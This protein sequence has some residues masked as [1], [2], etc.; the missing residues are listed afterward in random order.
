MSQTSLPNNWKGAQLKD[1]CAS[2]PQNG[3]FIKN[4]EFGSGLPFV[5]VKDIYRDIV[6]DLKSVERLQCDEVSA[7][8]YALK[9]DDILFVRSSLKRDGIGQCCVVTDIQEPAIYDCHLIRITPDNSKADALF[10]GY[11]FLSSRGKEDLI[12]RSRTTTMTT[13]NQKT[14]IETELVLPPIAEQRAIAHVLRALQ[15]AS[16]ARRKELQLERERKAALMR[17]LFTHGTRGEA[18]KTT[19]IGKLPES[20]EVASLGTVATQAQYGLSLRGNKTGTYPILRMNSLSDGGIDTSDLQYVELNAEIL[21]SFKLNKGDLL[22]NRT[23]SF[24]LVGKT[25]LFEAEGDYVFASYLVRVSVN[26]DS[27][28]PAFINEYL[29]SSTTQR[30]LK[31]M[32][33]RAVSQSNISASKLKGFTI[34]LPSLDEQEEISKVLRACNNKVTALEQETARLDE[35]FRAMLEELMTG[36]LP[37]QPLIED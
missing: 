26:A 20:W 7:R 12:A 9:K 36:R 2:D 34:P 32:A 1:V 10:L 14:L 11:Y 3:A 23:N 21:R 35:L 16:G 5:N 8:R 17:H 37:T 30:R 27:A 18:R 28:V 4:P 19:E 31:M 24:E 29:N 25:G 22:F 13:I 15:K 6:I 33:S